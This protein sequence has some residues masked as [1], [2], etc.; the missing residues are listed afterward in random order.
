MKKAFGGSNKGYRWSLDGK[1]WNIG[2]V[3]NKGGSITYE[4]GDKRVIISNCYKYTIDLRSKLFTTKEIEDKVL[5]VINELFA[6][7]FYEEYFDL[8]QGLE[9]QYGTKVTFKTSTKQQYFL[10]NNEEINKYDAFTSIIDWNKDCG[11]QPLTTPTYAE[12]LKL[13]LIQDFDIYDFNLIKDTIKLK[14]F[15]EKV[16]EYLLNRK[17][18]FLKEVVRDIDAIKGS[19]EE[20]IKN[21]S[22]KQEINDVLDFKDMFENA[23][24]DGAKAISQVI[25]N[26]L[27]AYDEPLIKK[28]LVSTMYE[29]LQMLA[30]QL[31]YLFS[32][33]NKEIFNIESMNDFYWEDTYGRFTWEYG[34]NNRL[35]W[36]N[37]TSSYTVVAD[38]YKINF[39]KALGTAVNKYLQKVAHNIRM[40]NEKQDRDVIEFACSFF[41][42]QRSR[43]QNDVRSFLD[44]ADKTPDDISTYLQNALYALRNKAITLHA[45]T[46][47]LINQ[48][49][50][51]KDG[52]EDFY[53][54]NFY[55]ADNYAEAVNKFVMSAY[56]NTMTG[57]SYKLVNELDFLY[58]GEI[59]KFNDIIDKEKVI[60][61]INEIKNKFI[62]RSRELLHVT[63]YQIPNDKKQQQFLEIYKNDKKQFKKILNQ[64][65]NDVILHTSDSVWDFGLFVDNYNFKEI[66]YYPKNSAKKYMEN[67]CKEYALRKDVI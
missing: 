15:I 9:T 35:F 30:Q 48:N 27:F 21:S 34:E 19:D 52:L 51:I 46:S 56:K 25:A 65:T 54:N 42:E 6:P 40:L 58:K 37:Y 33:I 5:I 63:F 23:L 55:L 39:D 67:I 61:Y 60:K 12:L 41:K 1:L 62:D 24:K 47:G 11:M 64:F 31:K 49:T 43:L 8:F 36:D 20:L 28:L 17:N 57:F 45:D 32:S 53:E 44:F 38:N 26:N 18:I 3:N 4:V 16:K 10:F 13:D 14:N 59:V 50:L 7:Y 2:E 29:I 66:Q 22:G